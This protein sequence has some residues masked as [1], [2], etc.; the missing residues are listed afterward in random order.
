MSKLR[1]C[2]V[3]YSD[4]YQTDGVGW[5]HIRQCVS[6]LNQVF[7]VQEDVL[8]LI[9]HTFKAVILTTHCLMFTHIR[10][11]THKKVR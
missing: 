1:F 3:K 9:G 2:L 8:N 5:T 6:P 10:F 7:Q 4:V 11:Y